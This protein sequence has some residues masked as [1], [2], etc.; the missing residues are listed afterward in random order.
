[1]IHLLPDDLLGHE[2]LAAVRAGC[3][4]PDLVALNTSTLDGPKLDFSELAATAGAL[5]FLADKRLVVVRGYLAQTE[6]R[7]GD[8][9]EKSEKKKGARAERLQQLLDWLP[10]VP[11]TTE[12]VFLEPTVGGKGAAGVTAAITKL[13]GEVFASR[14]LD[15]TQ[16][17]DFALRRA[18]AKG[19]R[20]RPDAA[21]QLGALVAGDLRRLDTELDK[22]LTYKASPDGSPAEITL[23]DVR[24]LVGDGREQSIFELVDSIGSRDRRRALVL[25][26]DM[27][28]SGAAAPYVLT[29]IVRQFRLLI[30]VREALATSSDQN[31]IAAALKMKPWQVRNLGGQARRFQLAELESAYRRLLETDLA[32]KTGKLEPD[33]AVELLVAELI[34]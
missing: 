28:Q 31:A 33:L 18:Q 1:M 8:A 11:P 22:L 13:G 24:L 30:Q 16:L 3:G 20:I 6:P 29:M 34:G 15:A 2:R 23:A 10:S 25:L 26:R 9:P 4:E 5:P 17:A 7:D 19:G 32:I 14:T 27:L 12:L 21:D